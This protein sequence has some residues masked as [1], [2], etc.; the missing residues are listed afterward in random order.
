MI[1]IYQTINVT[2][3]GKRLYMA[4]DS[5]LRH[6][7]RP[8]SKLPTEMHFTDAPDLSSL[9]SWI[10]IASVPSLPIDSSLYPELF[11]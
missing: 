4:V 6:W 8:S 3:N 5:L 7:T 1:D 10:H 9:S 2:S 11:I